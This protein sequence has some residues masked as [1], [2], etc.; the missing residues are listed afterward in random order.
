[1]TLRSAIKARTSK[2]LIGAVIIASIIFFTTVT[3]YD[4]SKIVGIIRVSDTYTGHSAVSSTFNAS[5][6][7]SDNKINGYGLPLIDT[8]SNSR[9]EDPDDISI[10][11]E[12]R[13]RIAQSTKEEENMW[14][15]DTTL[16][17]ASL[18]IPNI[19]S[20]ELQ[21]FKERLDNSL[22]N[23]K[24]IGNFYF[25]DP[26]LTFSVYLK[27]I[28]D[29]L[30]SGSTTNLTIPFNWAHFRDLSS[31]NPY[32]DIKQEDK[33]ACDYFYESSNKDKRKPTGN[34]I[35][36]KDVRDE[37]LIQYGISSKDH[38]P[39]PFILKSLGI[40]MQHTAKR[41]ES[42]LYLLTGAPVPLSLS[43]MTKKGLYQVGVDQTGKL[44]PNIARTELW[45]FYK[46]GK[47][48]LQF[49]A[50]E[51]LS[52]LIETVPSS[53][54]SSSGEGYFTTELKENNFELP[55]SKND[56]TFDDS[57]VESLIKGLSEQD[58][59]LHTQRY[60]ESLQYSFATREN[61]VKK[62]FYEARM[63]INTVN[64]EG[65]AHYDWRFFNGAMNH[66]SS[67]FT[68]EE[69]QLR[70]RSVLHRLLR[71]WLVFNY[72]QGSPTWLAHGTLLSWYW[73]SLMFP[74]DYDI[75]VQMPIKSLNNLCAN[76]NQSLIIED[77]TEGY[78]SFFLDCGS[79]I[80][81]RTKGKGLNFID[82]RFINVETGLYIDI[83][84]LSTSQSARPPRFSNASK[85]DPIYNCRNNHFYSHNNIAPLKYT[86]M[87]GVP[88]F[89]PQQYEEILREEYTTG[90]TSKHYNGNFFMTQLNL[91][92]E[93][94]PMLA[95]VPSS[96]YEIEGGGVDHNKIIKSILELSN[97]KK[98]ELLDD[99]PDILEEVIRTYELT[100]IH[101]KE[102]QYL[103][104]VK[105]DG[106][107]SMQSN[108]ITSSYQEFL[109]SLKKFQ[110]LRKDL[111]QFERID[112]S[113]HRKQ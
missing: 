59:D 111:F 50:Q 113:K 62:Y 46:N 88:S 28:K 8:E 83:T 12:L 92:L 34:C 90:L 82:A 106:D 21:P 79:S 86:L 85:K 98:L 64:K 101:H 22:Y 2:G 93:R 102:M 97:I 112:L 19:Q 78:S 9:Y 109:A 47:E 25:Y 6:V 43:F 71:N 14:K 84:G 45:E 26:R 75:D 110:P 30:A 60:K 69:R 18:K 57:E 10:E 54:N 49:N 20:F 80:T 31:L 91:W 103:S 38:L 3:F 99:N 96:K 87:E 42:N 7:V 11:N 67:G 63:I 65:G 40:P 105:P 39:G 104:S 29:K 58:L 16:T 76:F 44:D 55:L 66:E 108:D 48:N 81:H 77:L 73:N 68:E 89:I 4:E 27:Y 72:Q 95:L 35:E 70:K 33:V 32:L 94:D 51:E 1:M 107:R 24:N 23:S 5:S 61:D 15:L 52:H 37:H 36:F 53:S 13:Y 56:F 74:W 41:L 100:S 17:E